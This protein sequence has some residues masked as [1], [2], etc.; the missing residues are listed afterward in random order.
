[1][2]NFSISSGNQPID[3]KGMQIRELKAGLSL[4]QAIEKT[5]DNGIDEAFVEADGKRYVIYSEDDLRIDSKANIQV[6]GK[7]AKV[8]HLSD[9]M[10][11]FGDG[12]FLMP[13]KGYR[14]AKAAIAP[15]APNPATALAITGGVVA[16]AL[17]RNAAQPLLANMDQLTLYDVSGVITSMAASQGAAAALTSQSSEEARVTAHIIASSVGLGGGL[18]LGA[19]TAESLLRARVSRNA[20]LGL[21]LGAAAGVAAITAHADTTSKSGTARTLRALATGAGSVGLGAA[22]PELVRAL[23]QI[24]VPEYVVKGAKVAGVAA[25]VGG[26]LAVFGPAAAGALKP[27]Q[28]KTIDEISQ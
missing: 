25:L 8:L 23:M 16:G 11:S 7:A 5:Q 19:G 24:R 26:T 2:S 9:E 14:I 3:T 27:A 17:A 4:E 13:S 10:N 28:T 6:E 21:G 15:I 18:T 12:L 1:M 22:S 20:G